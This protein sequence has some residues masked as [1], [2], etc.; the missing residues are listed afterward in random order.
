MSIYTV[1]ALIVLSATESEQMSSL[2]SCN[3]SGARF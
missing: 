3:P 1:K 2:V